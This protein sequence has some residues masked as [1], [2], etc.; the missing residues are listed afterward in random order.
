MLSAPCQLPRHHSPH[1]R[2]MEAFY[3]RVSVC[4]P[5]LDKPTT[6]LLMKVKGKTHTTEEM[7][8]CQGDLENTEQGS[9]NPAQ[10]GEGRED[11]LRAANKTA[12]DSTA[13]ETC[14]GMLSLSPPD[15]CF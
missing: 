15:F 11:T 1:C 6:V 14:N 9:S 2:C 10:S 5:K 12:R 8:G 3:T 13:W 7:P 4:H